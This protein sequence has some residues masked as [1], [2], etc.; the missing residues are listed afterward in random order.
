MELFGVHVA[1]VGLLCRAGCRRGGGVQLGV[2]GVLV[3]ADGVVLAVRPD[4]DRAQQVGAVDV[5]A[6]IPQDAQGLLMRVAV[7]V[8]HAAGDDAHFGQD[9][10]QEKVAR[11]GAGT[12]V[13]HL[14]NIGLQ[15]GPAVHQIAL[16]IRFHVA[17][18]EE[19]GGTIIDPQ[20]DRGVIRLTVLCHRAQ[21]RHRCTAQLPDG[22]HGGHLDLQALLLGVLHKILKALGGGFRHRAVHMVRREEGQRSGQPAHM[23]FMRVGA[24]DVLQLFHALLLQIADHHA[25]VVHV[26]AVVQ[27]V[28]AIALH[29]DAERLPHVE[30]V[31]PEAVSGLHPAGCRVRDHIGAA[32]RKD[33]CP[34]TGRKAQGQRSGQRQC[35]QPPERLSPETYFFRFV[36]FHVVFS[37]C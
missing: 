36:F 25:A 19:A 15:V 9:G 6:C 21:H 18:Q 10:I 34:V 33:G 24:E 27:H 30:K 5:H 8:V 35:G 17:G 29:Q 3:G 23:V 28:L 2:G 11:R 14:Q 22:A 31:H 20:D 16:C 1:D 37:F 4:D 13:A 32:A 26:A 12:V 7:F